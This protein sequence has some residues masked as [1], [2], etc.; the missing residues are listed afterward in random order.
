M[1]YAETNRT[2]PLIS[3]Y[4]KS[5]DIIHRPDST[6]SPLPQPTET[7]IHRDRAKHGLFHILSEKSMAVKI[8]GHDTTTKKIFKTRTNI[9]SPSTVHLVSDIG[10]VDYRLA[11]KALVR[12]HNKDRHKLDVLK[13]QL[14]PWL[15][16][17]Y[18]ANEKEVGS[19]RN[20]LLRWWRA[21]M[22]TVVHTVY[23][24]RS[25]YFESILEIMIRP[26]FVEFDRYGSPNYA[27]WANLNLQAGWGDAA[28]EE[29]Y[30]SYRA[31]LLN[32]LQYA[33]DR[34]NQKAVYSNVIVFCAKIFAL[35]F[36][37]IP[38][39][40]TALLQVLTLPRM[41]YKRLQQEIGCPGDRST[42]REDFLLY[43]PQH[44]HNLTCG[45]FRTFM[46]HIKSSKTTQAKPI[47]QVGNWLRR[48]QSD[49][50]ELF[51][52]FYKHYHVVLKE[53]MHQ[54]HIGAPPYSNVSNIMV[55]PSSV[56]PNTKVPASSDMPKTMVLSAA[57]AYVFLAAFFQEK[58]DSLLHREINSVTTI[59]QWDSNGIPR[60]SHLH[61][62][63]DEDPA[64]ESRPNLTCTSTSDDER[65]ISSFISNSPPPSGS[66]HG[67]P[68]VLELATRRYAD[69]MVKS[70]LCCERGTFH[71][72]ADVWI[73]TAIKRTKLSAVESI[74]CLFDL[75]ETIIND[76]MA[77]PEQGGM[78]SNV[79]INVA[80]VLETIR[81][82]LQ[83]SDHTITLVRTLSFVYTHFELL[84]RDPACMNDLCLN[85]LLHPAT[86]ERLFL[87]WSRNVRVFFIRTLIWRVGQV[88][89]D[90]QVRWDDVHTAKFCQHDQCWSRLHQCGSG[91]I[92]SF[93]A[94][95]ER[96]ALE[97]HIVL[98]SL[99][100]VFHTQ[101]HHFESKIHG[102][103][104]SE[105]S[106]LLCTLTCAELPKSI[107]AHHQTSPKPVHPI[108]P[109]HEVSR[110][111]PKR[112]LT[113][114]RSTKKRP[115]GDKLM[116]FF[117][118]RSAKASSRPLVPSSLEDNSSA[119]MKSSILHMSSVSSEEDD[120]Q[121]NN[122]AA[123][124]CSS[125][126]SYLESKSK[127][128]V[129]AMYVA[130]ANEWRYDL[131]SHVYAKKV[132]SESNT[133]LME[134][135]AWDP[136]AALSRNESELPC[137]GLDWPKNWTETS[138]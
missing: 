54:T 124:T 84:T 111:K 118:M 37:K 57:P 85:T 77:H 25:Y 90:A 100:I 94:A 74:F 93:N 127:N 126:I 8:F 18:L 67:K 49:D 119:T 50:S 63:Q 122:T 43:I 107:L 15:G 136:K 2:S 31:L 12:F 82:I 30:R 35:S 45:N 108:Y 17:R 66:N 69:C 21:L 40:S 79:P 95:Y 46:N 59:V 112:A 44:L 11:R 76:F 83:Q 88:W 62:G 33:I 130:H 99:L 34:L 28:T 7:K 123:S 29:D 96:S 117:S 103:P 68:K 105:K 48:W 110:E 104:E 64:C 47:E 121:S 132:V 52:A 38:G 125:T 39:M 6:L 4:E 22:N 55:P 133:A 70:V 71:G 26:E 23:N 56:V 13:H 16:R 91:S 120:S 24:E 36:F 41:K 80:Y 81:T 114:G 61:P 72:M 75:L 51:F 73:R 106:K 20:T 134:F 5:Q 60:D 1:L 53:Y 113:F 14:L 129:F 19:G 98:E 89:K 102:L 78:R 86:F 115:S 3:A 116:R 27:D 58:I 101:Y 135:E 97:A 92:S 9:T 10:Q 137:L 109:D 131:K 32:T 138:G 87:H 128:S 65:P 42:A